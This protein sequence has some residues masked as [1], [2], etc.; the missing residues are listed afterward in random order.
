MLTV[1]VVVVSEIHKMWGGHVVGARQ[2]ATGILL[3]IY[4]VEVKCQNLQMPVGVTVSVVV[5][6]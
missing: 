3:T 5:G 4:M 2:L 6:Q 1:D